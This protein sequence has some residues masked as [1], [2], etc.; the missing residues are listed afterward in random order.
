MNWKE[1]QFWC[2]RITAH[3]SLWSSSSSQ[4]ASLKYRFVL[5]LELLRLLL[6]YRPVCANWIFSSAILQENPQGTLNTSR[7]YEL[8]VTVKVQLANN[9]KVKRNWVGP[10]IHLEQIDTLSGDKR[11][12][13]LSHYYHVF[14]GKQTT[15]AGGG[16][17]QK[18]SGEDATT[19]TE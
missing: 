5:P 15:A 13:L 12:H 7:Q 9:T 11:G 4:E 14:V 19:V 8:E 3:C 2:Y 6:F 1:R 18:Q 10:W 16:R 17:G